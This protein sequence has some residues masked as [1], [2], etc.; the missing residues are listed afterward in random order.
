MSTN[1]C[2]K[3]LCTCAAPRDI[4]VM[5]DSMNKCTAS[6]S[7]TKKINISAD[8]VRVEAMTQQ[9]WISAYALPTQASEA[10]FFL[11]AQ[12][13]KFEMLRIMKN[14][15]MKR[16]SKKKQAC[17]YQL[18]EFGSTRIIQFL[19][20]TENQMTYLTVNHKIP[21]RNPVTTQK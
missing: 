9:S 17:S 2:I 20:C 11:I 18:N 1:D 4:L 21:A 19:P 13:L 16:F 5:K 3:I 10:P 7:N 6:N 8:L 14:Y 12:Q 15:K